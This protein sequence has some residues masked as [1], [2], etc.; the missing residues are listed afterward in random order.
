MRG[1]L[2]RALRSCSAVEAG[3]IPGKT[4]LVMME[5]PTN[6]RMQVPAPQPRDLCFCCCPTRV[7]ARACPPAYHFTCRRGW[8]LAPLVAHRRHPP[9]P[10]PPFHREA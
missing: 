5:S 9:P 10:P 6:P 7:V 8:R 3:L 4:A 1:M 2:T